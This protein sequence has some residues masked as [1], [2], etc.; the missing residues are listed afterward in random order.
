MIRMMNWILS[1]P[2]HQI[3]FDTSG[4]QPLC[5]HFWFVFVCLLVTTTKYGLSY[6]SRRPRLMTHVQGKLCGHFIHY[7][8]I[9]ILAY[10]IC[11]R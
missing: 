11:V 4:N 1:C 7:N 10:H 3:D 9:N 6:G 8:V 5:P 2:H